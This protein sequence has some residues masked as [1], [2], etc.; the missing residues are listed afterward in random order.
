MKDETKIPGNKNIVIQ[1]VSAGAITVKVNGEVREIRN[2]VGAL[3][4]LIEA[5]GQTTFQAGEKIYNI[6]EISE[7]QFTQII[8]Q[9]FA[10]SRTSRYLKLFLYIFVPVLAI[11][12][13]VLL[14]RYQQ[15]QQPLVFSVALENLTPNPELPFEKGKITLQYGDKTETQE[16]EHEAVFKSI[17]A[18][19]RGQPI[20]VHFEAQGF[21]KID[22][23]FTLSGT[24]LLLPIR[25]DSSLAKIFGT[26]KDDTGNPVADVQISVQD[27]TARSDAAGR[28][29]LLIPFDRQRKEQR[30]RAFKPSYKL[31]DYSSPVIANEEIDIILPK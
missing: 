19:F 5:Q 16:V 9:N 27:L 13:A 26:V 21:V 7:A 1:S 22:T 30:I 6:G 31:W 10:E 4:N 24:H 14:Y 11:A 2:E 17:P 3:Q 15:M 12:F 23:A 25:R 20:A 29:T 28:F 18:N 8:H